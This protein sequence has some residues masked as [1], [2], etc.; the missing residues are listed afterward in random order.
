MSD[1]S[2]IV[3]R[4]CPVISPKEVCNAGA[5]AW[6]FVFSGWRANRK[7]DS[8][9]TPRRPEGE[10]DKEVSHVDHS[11]VDPSSTVNP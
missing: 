1:A 10:R 6:A 3:V 5:R 2:R 7:E 4:S 9:T 8:E 11:S